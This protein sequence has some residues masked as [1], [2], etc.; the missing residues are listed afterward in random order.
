[1]RSIG[2][3]SCELTAAFLPSSL[4]R[5][6]PF[7]LVY[8]TNPPV[9][10][11]GTVASWLTLDDF[12]G[13][14][15]CRISPTLRQGIFA[16][17]GMCLA[18]ADGFTC[19]HSSRPERKSNNPPGVL[20]SVLPSRAIHSAGILTRFPSPAA[21]AIGL[22]PTNPQMI[23]IAA[24]TLGLRRPGLSPGLR[25]LVPTFSLANAPVALAG[26]P[27]LQSQCSSTAP[28]PKLLDVALHGTFDF[29]PSR[30]NCP[31]WDE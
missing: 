12:L 7:A 27:S 10:V 30:D 22:G 9:S 6:H 21:F 31:G 1:M 16:A 24:E 3:P 26:Q 11:Y 8:S 28:L 2:R 15:L 18:A 23:T 17:L 25:L 5:T 20:R 13:S 19:Q 4:T 29:C 14:A